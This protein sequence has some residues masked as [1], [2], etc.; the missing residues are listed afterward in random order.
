MQAFWPHLLTFGGLL[1][2]I[3]C[4]LH[5]LVVKRDA[6]ATIAWVGLIWL[7]PMVGAFLYVLFGVNRIHRRAKKCASGRVTSRKW[8]IHKRPWTARRSARRWERGATIFCR[9]SA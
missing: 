3:G 1:L 7:T 5:A 6:R 9:W 8:R 2:E 4:T